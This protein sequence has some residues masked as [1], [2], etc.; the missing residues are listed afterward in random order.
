M[1]FRSS[2][3]KSAGLAVG[4]DS[5]TQLELAKVIGKA[6]VLVDDKQ[7]IVYGARRLHELANVM[8]VIQLFE[9]NAHQ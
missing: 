8:T 7:R 3:S 5:V 9:S 4:P 6:F 1:Y 2:C